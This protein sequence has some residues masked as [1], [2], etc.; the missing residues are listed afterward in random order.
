MAVPIHMKEIISNLPESSG[1]YKF[2]D[3]K[4]N[5]LYI[6]KSKNIKKR[7]TSY[8]LKQNENTHKRTLRLIFHIHQIEIIKTDTEL[9]ALILEDNLI[10]QYLP[11]YNI[12][13]KKF[14]EQVYIVIT[15]D[16]FPTIKIIQ[17]EGIE[18][19]DQFFGPFKDKFAAEYI[20]SIINE[21]LCLR[22]CTYPQPANKCMLFGIDKCL[23]PCQKNIS[24]TEYNIFVQVAIK[25]LKGNPD[26][27]IELIN[28]K[29]TK[30]ASELQF[31]DAAKFIDVRV[32]CL[33]FSKRQRFISDFKKRNLIIKSSQ[34]NR[35]F[36]FQNSELIKIYQRKP[37][38]EM[39]KNCFQIMR[40]KNALNPQ[41]LMDR[42]Y[43][44]WVWVKQNRA[45]YEFVD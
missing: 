28:Q 44:V 36:L 24:I 13:Q 38:D 3:E 18:L 29:I 4:G 15:S 40:N 42:A 10:K 7:V 16:D 31:E 37:T 45:K 9:E 32:F 35:T 14:K 11:Q 8:F 6:G 25:F 21:V 22:S 19:F 2:F 17:N 41:Y 30:A 33:N 43:V 5:L 20:I 34:T 23:G 27:I 39:I 12:K 26:P 1:I